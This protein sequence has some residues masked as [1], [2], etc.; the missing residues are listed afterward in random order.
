MRKYQ[1]IWADRQ[2]VLTVKKAYKFKSMVEITRE[3]NKELE[4][5]LYGADINDDKKR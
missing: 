1:H 2:F 5:V 4:K 3:L